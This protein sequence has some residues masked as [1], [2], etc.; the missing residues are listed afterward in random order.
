MTKTIDSTIREI[1]DCLSGHQRMLGKVSPLT[2]ELVD[3]L[4]KCHIYDSLYFVEHVLHKKSQIDPQNKD[5]YTHIWNLINNRNQTFTQ[6]QSQKVEAVN[7]RIN[8]AVN[9][10]INKT[11]PSKANCQLTKRQLIALIQS[12]LVG[13]DTEA[14]EQQYSAYKWIHMNAPHINCTFEP[15]TVWDD[16][17]K[18]DIEDLVTLLNYLVPA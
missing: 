5:Y 18:I 2:Q 3:E 12:Q 17:Q 9:R 15:C 4:A 7:R 6:S 13:N 16:I 8:E 1:V 10:R 14:R 11:T